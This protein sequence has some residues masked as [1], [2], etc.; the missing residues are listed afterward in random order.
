MK[1]YP[2]EVQILLIIKFTMCIYEQ[3]FDLLSLMTKGEV[4]SICDEIFDNPFHSG[5]AC[6]K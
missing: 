2:N 4:C 1:E 5:V 6:P 3:Y